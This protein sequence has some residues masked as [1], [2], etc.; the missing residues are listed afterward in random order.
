MSSSA[1]PSTP[2]AGMLAVLAHCATEWLACVP[3]DTRDFP[4]DL[5]P[6]VAAALLDQCAAA[7]CR[8]RLVLR[9]EALP[10]LPCRCGH[11]NKS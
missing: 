10:P 4:L 1:R 5:V 7:A 2:L 6:R 3:C 11:A 9:G 8:G